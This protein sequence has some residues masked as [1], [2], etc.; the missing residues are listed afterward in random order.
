[1]AAMEF[2]SCAAEKKRTHERFVAAKSSACHQTSSAPHHEREANPQVIATMNFASF[3][4]AK[5]HEHER[6]VSTKSM[7]RATGILPVH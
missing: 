1:M 2:A 7:P 6:F 5:N 4:A 3:I